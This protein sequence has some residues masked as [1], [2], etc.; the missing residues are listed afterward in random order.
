LLDAWQIGSNREIRAWSFDDTTVFVGG[1]FTNIAGAQR[2]RAAEMSLKTGLA[3]PWNPNVN[4]VVESIL[5]KRWNV[6]LAGG[7]SSI[8]NY[9]KQKFAEVD[10]FTS[11]PTNFTINSVGDIAT[12]SFDFDRLY[13]GGFIYKVD[14][15]SRTNLFGYDDCSKTR[16]DTLVACDS[17]LG[18]DGV[19]YTES[20]S[21]LWFLYSDTTIQGCDSILQLNLTINPYPD[22]TVQN[23]NNVLIANDTSASYQW[24]DCNTNLPITGATQRAFQPQVNGMYQVEL[25]KN[26]CVL[27][28]SCIA[29]TTI[30]VEDENLCNNI[31][32]YPNPSRGSVFISFTSVGVY[33]VEVYSLSGSLVQSE[34]VIT[35]TDVEEKRL[36]L[37]SGIY[38]LKISNTKNQSVTYQKLVV[39]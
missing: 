32:I 30:G 12:L 22:T 15:Y 20:N 2:N 29:V 35:E 13:C 18:I 21:R 5:V 9:P 19:L 3:K 37:S 17:Y 34:I 11:V 24:F 4:N 1:H 26:N 16:F 23:V 38:V 10:R 6:Y 14:G 36:D 39:L 8:N 28:S 25:Q 31:A 7:F 33:A 27:R